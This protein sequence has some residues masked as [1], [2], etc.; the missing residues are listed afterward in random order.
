[1]GLNI[2]RCSFGDHQSSKT[3]ERVHHVQHAAQLCRISWDKKHKGNGIERNT[4]NFDI[5]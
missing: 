4:F 1:M 2:L 5:C 3:I